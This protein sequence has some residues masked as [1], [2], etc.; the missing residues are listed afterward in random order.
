MNKKFA[1]E[2]VLRT[3]VNKFL[4]DI[5]EDSGDIWS[6]P[7]ELATSMTLGPPKCSAYDGQLFNLN[8]N[9]EKTIAE[10]EEDKYYKVVHV[11]KD[12]MIMSP[13]DQWDA[14]SY[15]LQERNTGKLS[16]GA[17]T[18]GVVVYAFVKNLAIPE[19]SE[20]GTIAVEGHKAGGL[21]RIE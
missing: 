7:E 5:A 21:R 20:H 4:A 13:E 2:T 11:I 3:K 6:Y 16:Y 1:K 15:I 12:R 9:M 8:E 10:I 18:H 17:Y 19:Y 14:E